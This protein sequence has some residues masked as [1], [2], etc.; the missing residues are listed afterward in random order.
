VQVL[1]AEE[2]SAWDALYQR[3]ASRLDDREAQVAAVAE[4]LEQGMELMG[5]TAIE[6][7]LQVQHWTVPVTGTCF[8]AMT[9]NLYHVDA[10][11]V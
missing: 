2:W 6:D 8:L 7:K 4:S 5:V 3:A 11:R 10:L 1:S 9:C